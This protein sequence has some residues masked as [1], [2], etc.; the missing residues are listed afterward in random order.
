V[1][2]GGASHQ[3]TSRAA[4][5]W[6]RVSDRDREHVTTQLRD[7]FVE[8]RL[9]REELDERITAALNARTVG[10]LRSITADLP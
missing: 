10:D 8:G 2:Q 4:D 5:D 6:I 1:P 9:T 3:E 7:S